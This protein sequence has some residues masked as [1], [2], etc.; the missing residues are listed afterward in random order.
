M[1]SSVKNE[2]PWLSK[3]GRGNQAKEQ[4]EGLQK[5]RLEGTVGGY[6][7]IC[8][9]DHDDDFTCAQT[10]QI[11]CFKC[12]VYYILFILNFVLRRV[13]YILD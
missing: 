6:S 2:N 7:Y 13:S 12:V 5:G 4:K 9:L 10:H 11:I 8:L 1:F 3:K